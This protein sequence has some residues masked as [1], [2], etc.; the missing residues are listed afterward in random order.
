MNFELERMVFERSDQTTLEIGSYVGQAFGTFDPL[1]CLIHY[2]LDK[3]YRQYSS[4]PNSEQATQHFLS[5]PQLL[6]IVDN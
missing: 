5:R 3:F 6:P 2:L 4:F 1:H